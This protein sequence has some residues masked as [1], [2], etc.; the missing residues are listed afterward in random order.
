MKRK[1]AKKPWTRMTASELAKAT[2]QFDQEI[3]L[4]HTRPLS[5]RNRKWWN[6]A[7]RA[8][9]PKV[10]RGARPVLITVEQE[11]LAQADAYAKKHGINRS[12]L[13]ALGIQ[14]LIQK[15]AG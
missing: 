3:D 2:K 9:R 7:K 6:R 4:D 13:V 1:S 14:T 12:Q 11:L 5:P 8:G 10:G 15:R